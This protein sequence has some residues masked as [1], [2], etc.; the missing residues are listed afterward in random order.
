MFRSLKD[1]VA[2]YYQSYF[3][4][5]KVRLSNESQILQVIAKL[6]LIKPCVM[7]MRDVDNTFWKRTWQRG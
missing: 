1:F 6:P 2:L 7:T 3:I 5:Q 4:T